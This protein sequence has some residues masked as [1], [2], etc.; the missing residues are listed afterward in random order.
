MT[1]WKEIIFDVISLSQTGVG[2]PNPITGVLIRGNVDKSTCPKERS[3]ENIQ[4]DDGVM[5]ED[6][7]GVWPSMANGHLRISGK[8]EMCEQ[9]RKDFPP[10]VSEGN[11]LTLVKQQ[12]S[13]SV[14]LRPPFVGLC[15]TA[16]AN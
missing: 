2:C 1:L 13:I 5:T 16:L 3:H 14:L 7:V 4:E 9:S 8:N 10:Q 12:I 15:Y 6:E 11:T